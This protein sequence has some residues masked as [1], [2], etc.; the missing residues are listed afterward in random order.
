MEENKNR[1]ELVVGGRVKANPEV[2]CSVDGDVGGGDRGG[3]SGRGLVVE[4]V[5]ET[6]V[7]SAIRTAGVVD[8]GGDH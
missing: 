2:T 5:N 3:R 4:E 1:K 8:D 7:D 6:T